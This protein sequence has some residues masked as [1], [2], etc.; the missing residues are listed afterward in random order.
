[1]ATHRLSVAVA[2]GACIACQQ[3]S[4][5][6]PPAQS[7]APPVQKVDAWQRMKECA[8][9]MERIGKQNKWAEGQRTGDLQIAGWHNHYSPKYDR[10]FISIFYINH[11]AAKNPI[12]PLEYEELVDAFENRYLATCTDAHTE[13]AAAFCNVDL[14]DGPHSDYGACR[15]FVNDRMDK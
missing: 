1:A 7:T 4:H 5:T 12:L 9:Q 13:Q 6:P 14:P 11:A 8:D 3:Q 2:F 15:A 10:C